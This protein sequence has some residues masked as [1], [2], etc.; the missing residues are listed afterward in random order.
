[1]LFNFK[2]FFKIPSIPNYEP[3]LVQ[4]LPGIP[5]VVMDTRNVTSPN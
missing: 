3:A 4:W 1:M 5:N 2:I